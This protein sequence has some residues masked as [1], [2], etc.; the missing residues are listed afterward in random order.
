KQGLGKMLFNHIIE[1]AKK[2][3]SDLIQLVVWDFN[4]DAI[5]FYKALGMTNRNIRMELQL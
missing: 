1:D 3:E 4:K 2:N 5:K